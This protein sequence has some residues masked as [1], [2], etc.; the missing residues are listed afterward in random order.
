MLYY[1]KIDKNK[2]I[3]SH[4]KL[5]NLK[6]ERDD[7]T[8]ENEYIQASCSLYKKNHSIKPHKHISNKRNIDITQEAWLVFNGSIKAK[9]YD[10]DNSLFDEVILNKGDCVILFNGG[11]DFITIKKNTIL[12]EF[13]NG[14][15]H[16]SE[17][18]RE[19]IDR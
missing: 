18:D 6:K 17:K 1:S 12:Y 4:F 15:Y 16:G 9:F 10:I 5:T 11:H 13:K 7:F 14:P 8:P 2:V 19:Y 3:Y